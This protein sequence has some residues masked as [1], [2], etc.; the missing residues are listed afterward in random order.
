MMVCFRRT[1]HAWLAAAALLASAPATADANRGEIVSTTSGN[2]GPSQTI[3]SNQMQTVPVSGTAAT[4]TLQTVINR[5]LSTNPQVV[6]ARIRYE[7]AQA[8]IGEAIAPGRPQVSVGASDTYSSARAFSSGGGGN[9]SVQPQGFIPTV[10]DSAFGS[11]GSTTGSAAVSSISSSTTP[12]SPGS[13]SST[14]AG[15]SPVIIPVTPVPVTNATAPAI[16]II[17][18]RKGT[19]AAGAFPGTFGN[20]SQGRLNNYG[21]NGSVT[22]LIDLFGLVRKNK[23]VLEQSAAFYLQDERRVANDLALNTKNTFFGALRAQSSLVTAEEQ[24]NNA[25]AVLKNTQIRKDAGAIA[26]FDVISAQTQVSNAR[27]ALINARNSMRVETENL[28]NLM[29]MPLDTPISL[30]RVDP[31]AQ[32]GSSTGDTEVK[33]ALA[34]RPEIVQSALAQ[35]IAATLVDLNKAGLYPSAGLSSLVAYNPFPSTGQDHYTA[36]IGASINIPLSDGGATRARVRAARLDQQTQQSVRTQLKQNVELEVRTSLAN[37]EDA[38]ALVDADEQGVAQA[39]ESLRL[40]NIR[41]QAGVGTLLEVTNAESNLTT[42]EN[43]LTTAQFQVQ[44]AYASLLRAEG[45]R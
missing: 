44:T 38:Q 10:Q 17:H 37:V 33:A 41:Y 32:L 1:A 39:R 35:Q 21:A 45:L 7:R 29:S 27:Q 4:V 42:A 15:S 36:S 26:E 8:I 14:Q 28:N 12:L 23:S 2:N 16:Q 18:A 40:A 9:F 31:P 22:Q 25:L 11:L 3:A 20:G 43:N 30:S 34:N 6:Q 19:P 24:L 13:G 5:V